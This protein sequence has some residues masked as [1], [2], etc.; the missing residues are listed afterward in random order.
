LVCIVAA[1][2]EIVSALLPPPSIDRIFA[3]I[4]LSVALPLGLAWAVLA[5][6]R[7]QPRFLQTATAL[8]G[9][10]VLAE[11]ALYPLG[12]LIH[13]MGSESLLAVPLE[14]LMLAGFIWYMVACANIW[15]AALDA[16]WLVGGAVSVGFLLVSLALEHQ[17][18]PDT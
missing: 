1:L 6:T 17:W 9:V 7:R 11:L 16:G 14:V 12:S 15:R 18:L 13:V 10:G 8:M 4:V 2:F 5:V 3:R